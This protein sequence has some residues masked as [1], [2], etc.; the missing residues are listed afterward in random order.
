MC[1][2]LALLIPTFLLSQDSR[3]ILVVTAS[4]GDYVFAAGATIAAFVQQGWRVDVAQLANEEKMSAGLTPAQT[5]LANVQEGRAA[6]KLLGVTNVVMMDHK[7][8]ELAYVSSTE[9]RAQLFALIRGIKP[10]ILFIPDPY[11]H[12][13]DDRDLYWTGKMSE[14]AWG[15][16]GGATFA[17][18]LERMGFTPY[19][20]PEIFYY[21]ARPYRPGEGGEAWKARF[22]ARDAGEFLEHKIQ[23]AE[24][25]NT[26]NRAWTAL[27]TGWF[28]DARVRSFVRAWI[29][30]LAET[31]GSRHGLRYA[32]EFN[33]VGSP[34]PVPP[35]AL[36][37][38]RPRN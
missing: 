13:Q 17:N 15:Y 24:L 20:A 3:R 30:E 12:Y 22:I 18:E 6:A 1:R 2:L 35:Y 33:H 5:R 28:D 9:M 29:T 34:E 16:S 14:E 4:S 11:V 27:R 25:L 31:I 23:A 37:R 19:G 10:R 8:G 36:D 21:A 26:R 7:S 32:E 38:A